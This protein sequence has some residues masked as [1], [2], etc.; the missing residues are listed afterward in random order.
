MQSVRV[1]Y[2]ISTR[3]RAEYLDRT[4]LNVR[5]FITPEDELLIM[6]GASTDGTAEV[7]GRHGD[8]VTCF[9]S[10]PD[11]GEAHGF[12]KGLLLARG[13]IIKVL[14]DDDYIYPEAMR[15][16]IAVMEAHGDVDAM[17]C[18]GELVEHDA[19]TGEERIVGYGWLPPSMRLSGNIMG[20]TYVKC[21]VGLFLR[22]RVLGRV[23]LFDTTFRCVDTEY[24]GRLVLCGVNFQYLDLKLYRHTTWSH[25]GYNRQSETV[26]DWLR[27]RL[28]AGAWNE[29]MDR[30]KFSPSQVG[31]VLGL[32]DL[33]GGDTLMEIVWHADRIRKTRRPAVLRML[34]GLVKGVFHALEASS[35]MRR[36][37]RRLARGVPTEEQQD[38]PPHPTTEPDWQGTLR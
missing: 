10:E 20:V 5:E 9:R 28:R 3:N 27:V 18:G 15:Q 25:S 1:S 14:T 34:Q 8:I 2:I 4:L 32:K 11:C 23:G 12:N 19:A 6:D 17:I 38:L 16:A 33:P 24:M 35:G 37:F 29:L 21:G 22:R 31:E 13:E 7:V 30:R 36:A 26:R